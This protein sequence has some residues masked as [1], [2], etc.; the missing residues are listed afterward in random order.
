VNRFRANTLEE[1]DSGS[2]RF[3]TLPWEG[4]RKR[5]NLRTALP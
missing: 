5:N 1:P 4:L 2:I 3:V